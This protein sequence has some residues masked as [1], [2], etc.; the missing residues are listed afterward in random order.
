MTDQSRYAELFRSEAREHLGTMTRLLL[1]P[2]RDP[3]RPRLLEELFR[4]VHT[5]KGSSAAMGY[6]AASELAHGLEH[7]L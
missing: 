2:E 5:L 4:S 6:E 7:L 1:L 3:G